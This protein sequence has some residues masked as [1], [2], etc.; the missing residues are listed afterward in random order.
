MKSESTTSVWGM[1]YPHSDSNW[2][3][4]PEELSEVFAGVSDEGINRITHLNAMDWF[5]YDPL[6]GFDRGPIAQW[7]TPKSPGGRP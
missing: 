7:E 5:S 2:P 3:T 1:D 4:A 6:P